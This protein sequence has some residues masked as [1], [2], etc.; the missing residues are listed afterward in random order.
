MTQSWQTVRLGLRLILVGAQTIGWS[1]AAAFAVGCGG[2]ALLSA[3]EAQPA[4]GWYALGL[5]FIATIMACAIGRLLSAIG[6]W[7]CMATPPEAAKARARI[8][9]T[10]IFE[11][12]SL[13]SGTVTVILIATGTLLPS[14][15]GM[16]GVG[17]CLLSAVLSRVL[18]FA[19]VL[20]VSEDV[21]GRTTTDDAKKVFRISLFTLGAAV[22][23]PVLLAIGNQIRGDDTTIL[24]YS[25]FGVGGCLFCTAAVFVLYLFVGHFI[26]ITDL[27]RHLAGNKLTVSEGD[28]DREYLERHLAGGGSADDI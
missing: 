17:F 20:A 6:R 24:A 19:F 11:T 10:V 27:R 12:C 21:Q 4:A 13:L 5:L 15:V 25:I 3:F 22:L 7:V 2:T 1:L 8:R 26:L 28:P 9:L 18:F 23:G 16:L 14:E